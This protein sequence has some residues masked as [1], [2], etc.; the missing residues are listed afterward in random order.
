MV[1][2]AQSAGRLFRAIFEIVLWR[3][4]A[5]LAQ[6]KF[7]LFF[8]KK[9]LQ[10][11]LFF[12]A[13]DILSSFC[14]ILSDSLAL[15]LLLFFILI[16]QFS[17]SPLSLQNGDRPPM[18]VPQPAAPIQENPRRS[19]SFHRQ[20]EYLLRQT[21]RF[22]SASAR[23]PHQN[24][25]NGQAAIQVHQVADLWK[26]VKIFRIRK[27]I[28]MDLLQNFQTIPQT[29]DA[30]AD[31]ADHSNHSENWTHHHSRFPVGWEVNIYIPYK[32][33]QRKAIF[34]KFVIFPECTA[35]RRVS[36][37]SWKMSTASWFCTTSTSCS[38]RNSRPT[39]TSSKCSCL[40]SIPC[41]PSTLSESCP[42]DGWDLKR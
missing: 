7:M 2:I 32:I 4:W 15:K 16:Y 1:F 39:S 40:F 27:K 14:I 8:L 41:R 5:A 13:S 38:S 28:E 35:V 33:K 17:E 30:D 6:V 25:Q 37:F 23:R 3:G 19:C 11:I 21:V 34:F 20:E 22:G 42:I 29:G 18:A 24:A 36:G 9:F 10:L 26:D 12:E 31:S